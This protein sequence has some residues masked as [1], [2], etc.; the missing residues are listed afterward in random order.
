M[1]DGSVLYSF[2]NLY[3]P[4][5]NGDSWVV[6][7]KQNDKWQSETRVTREQ[8]VAFYQKKDREL[9]AFYNRFLREL[10]VQK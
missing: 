9:R 7:Y 10:G 2:Q 5:Q 3:S 1:A 6:H 8:A 4:I